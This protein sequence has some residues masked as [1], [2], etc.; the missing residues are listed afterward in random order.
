MILPPYYLVASMPVR[1]AWVPGGIDALR[2]RQHIDELAQDA[3][4]SAPAVAQVPHQRMRLVLGDDPDAADT[5]IDCVRQGEIDD[6]EIAPD[7]DRRLRTPLCEFIQPGAAATR[8]YQ[9][10]GIPGQ[11]ADEALLFPGTVAHG[12]GSMTGSSGSVKATAVMDDDR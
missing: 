12:N 1:S 3:L 11:Q 8:K 2:G 5:G 7:M 4:E 6:P 10:H 9:G